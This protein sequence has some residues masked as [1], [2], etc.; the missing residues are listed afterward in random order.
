METQV[1]FLR[2]KVG[3]MEAE[4]RRDAEEREESETQV[5]LLREKLGSEIMREKEEREELEKEL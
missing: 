3:E 1:N 4:V 5:S 2:E